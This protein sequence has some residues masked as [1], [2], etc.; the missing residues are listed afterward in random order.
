MVSWV[1]SGLILSD[2][3]LEGKRRERSLY[4]AWADV[5]EVN[6]EFRTSSE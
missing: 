4:R 3:T 2:S 5:E 1:D 6:G